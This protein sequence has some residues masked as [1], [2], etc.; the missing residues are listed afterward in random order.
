[1]SETN[2]MEY[3]AKA[4]TNAAAGVGLTSYIDL[5]KGAT[6]LNQRHYS[7]F[8][9]DKPMAAIITVRTTT[10]DGTV[11]VLRNN[12]VTRNALVKTAAAWR[13][14]QRKAGISKSQLNRY[15]KE[16]RLAL[17]PDH[18]NAWGYLSD[19]RGNELFPQGLNDV[20]GSAPIGNVRGY[21]TG[22]YD[23]S[24]FQTL[25]AHQL[26]QSVPS[27]V[28]DYG[29]QTVGV[30]KVDIQQAFDLSQFTIPSADADTDASN[31]TWFVQ[32]DDSII[33]AY[34][35][36]RV[37]EIEIE[38][39]DMEDTPAPTNT[40]SLMLS[41]NEETSDD[42]IDDIEDVGDYR[43]YHLTYANSLQKTI[44]GRSVVAGQDVQMIVPLG[45]MKWTPAALDDQ[46]FITL[47][48]I[49]EM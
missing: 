22:E 6:I 8:R 5:F 26:E 10:Q 36:S 41:D 43:P 17:N 49:V 9:S 13:K 32:G 16:L 37:R 23:A 12:W 34:I 40:L 29:T 33:E 47:D 45:L 21:L 28:T 19:A 27:S 11:E 1:M 30:V 35:G 20:A 44:D 39:D 3:K 15:G 4:N 25:V 18:H 38:D 2:L 42:V 24:G 46:L 14:M 31:R 48:A 7:Q